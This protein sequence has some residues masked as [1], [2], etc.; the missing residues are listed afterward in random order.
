LQQ[1]INVATVPELLIDADA[2]A[3]AWMQAHPESEP[4][5]IAYSVKRCC[6]GGKICAVSVRKASQRDQPG[7]FASARLEDGSVIRVDRRA[8]AR[9]PAGFGLTVR[10]IGPLKHLDL[11]L[12]PEGWGRLLYD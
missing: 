11:D 3:R 10:G 9:L 2:A 12:D 1:T 4:R 5:V 6:G 7:V 8:A